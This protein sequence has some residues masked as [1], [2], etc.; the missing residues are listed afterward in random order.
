MFT[1]PV[2]DPSS[3][4]RVCSAGSQPQTDLAAAATQLPPS[5]FPRLK[6][7]GFQQLLGQQSSFLAFPNIT[8]MQTEQT[9]LRLPSEQHK[10]SR[11]RRQPFHDQIQRGEPCV[12]LLGQ[13]GGKGCMSCHLRRLWQSPLLAT[14][15]HHSRSW[16]WRTDSS[17]GRPQLVTGSKAA[18][19][20]GCL[21]CPGVT[22][23]RQT[24][25]QEGI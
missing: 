7:R 12:P 10:L 9:L 24:D 19:L 1:C 8:A 18:K 21:H 17:W 23:L 4:G 22:L 15:S 25:H 20:L 13:G 5:C 14:C 11:G 2:Q 3:Q 16:G 6:C